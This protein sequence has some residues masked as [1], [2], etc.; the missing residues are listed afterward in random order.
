MTIT[1]FCKRMKKSEIIAYTYYAKRLD[2]TEMIIHKN[3]TI[4]LYEDNNC[5]C[6]DYQPTNT[7]LYRR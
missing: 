3:G 5:I 1:N 4:D 7:E 2:A 6:L